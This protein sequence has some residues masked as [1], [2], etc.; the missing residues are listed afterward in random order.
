M[1]VRIDMGVIFNGATVLALGAFLLVLWIL[2]SLFNIIVPVEH[3]G[4]LLTL[5]LL[6]LLGGIVYI[7]MGIRFRRR[8]L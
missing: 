2:G 5:S 1:P 4:S 8:Y 3:L 6:M 7:F